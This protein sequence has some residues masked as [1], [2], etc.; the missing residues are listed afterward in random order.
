MKIRTVVLVEMVIE[1]E[2]PVEAIHVVDG[3]LDNG[4]FQDPINGHDMPDC[5]PLKVLSSRIIPAT[6]TQE[7]GALRACNNMI[8]Q[9][10]NET[11]DGKPARAREDRSL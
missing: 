8:E 10:I 9:I 4:V 1:C 5:G 11:F 7:E 2:N 3:L 6:K